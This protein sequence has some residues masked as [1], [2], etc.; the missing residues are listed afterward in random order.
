MD[1]NAS[2]VMPRRSQFSTGFWVTFLAS[3]RPFLEITHSA[4]ILQVGIFL[5][6]SAPG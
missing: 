4:V 3:S 2:V 1:V 5:N 6:P